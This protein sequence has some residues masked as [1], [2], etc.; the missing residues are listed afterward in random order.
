[1][2]EGSSDHAFRAAFDKDETRARGGAKG[3]EE[4]DSVMRLVPFAQTRT[5][6]NGP[7]LRAERP[8]LHKSGNTITSPIEAKIGPPITW[9]RLSLTTRRHVN[10]SIHPRIKARREVETDRAT[11]AARGDE[12]GGGAGA[13]R[14]REVESERKLRGSRHGCGHGHRRRQGRS[15]KRPRRVWPGSL[16]ERSGNER[17]QRCGR[18]R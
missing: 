7:I 17:R 11:E 15:R 16:G 14:G 5:R 4:K 10:T 3:D 9:A 1:M 8:A 2:N 12:P 18:G 13:G 6:L